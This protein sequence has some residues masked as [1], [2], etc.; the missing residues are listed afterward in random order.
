M[1]GSTNYDSHNIFIGDSWFASV[2]TE[3]IIRRDGG[4]FKGTP[5]MKNDIIPEAE[6]KSLINTLPCVAN[7]VMK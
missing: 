2:L 7:V 5:N 4:R 1:D 3:K 6:L